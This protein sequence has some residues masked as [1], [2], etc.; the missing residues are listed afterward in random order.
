MFLSNL[1]NRVAGAGAVN[2]LFLRDPNY[3]YEYKY[4]YDY[5]YYDLFSSTDSTGVYNILL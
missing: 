5:Y 1:C 3:E 2:I 4:D